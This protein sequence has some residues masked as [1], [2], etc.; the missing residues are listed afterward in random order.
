MGRISSLVIGLMACLMAASVR[1]ED[2]YIFYTWNVTYGTVAPLGVEQQG[3]LINGLFPGPEINC[4][5][6]NNIVVNVFNFLDEPLLFTWHGIQHRKNSWQDGTLGA[7]CPILPGTNYTYHFQV[8]DQIGS[9]FYY[10]SIGMHRAVGGFGGL[11]I[12][13]RLLIPVPYADP[14][15]EFWVLI[16]DWYGKSHQTLSQFLDSGRSIGR[17]SGVHINGKNGGLEPA[18]TME[19]GKTYKYRICNVGI[20]D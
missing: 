8:K 19:P 11:R 3:I 10:P 14:A 13:S 4:S 16:G 18:Y 9:Y 5:S 7:Q 6:N 15:D 20:K 1:G 2:P 12:Y 17:P